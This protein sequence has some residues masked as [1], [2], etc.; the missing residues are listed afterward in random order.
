M[1]RTLRVF[2]TLAAILDGWN[3]QLASG[4]AAPAKETGA[5]ALHSLAPQTEWQIGGVVGGRL[6]VNVDEWLLR[7]PGANPGMIEMFRVR[8]RQPPPQLVPWAGE[9]AGKYLISAVQALMLTNSPALRDHLAHFVPEL[10]A[11]Q[12]DDGYIG[13][14]P[15]AER[16]RGNWDLWGHY[17]VMQGL[18]LWHEF[19]GDEESLRTTRRAADLI[20]NTYLGQTRRVFD[21]GS[22][23]MNMAVLHVLVQLHRLTG[24][25]RYLSM[26]RE[27]EKDWERAGDYLRSGLA[28]TEFF[29]SPRPRWESLPDLQG[30]VELWRVTGDARYR[31]AFLHQWRSIARFD[32]HN[33]GGFSSGEQATGNPWN[34]AAIETCCT[35]AWMALSVDALRLTGDP[36]VADELELSLLN[37]G[38]GAQHP[39]GRWWTYNTPMDG[40][41]EAS[42]HSIVFQARAGT[43][44][45]N[46]CSVNAP[47]VLGL[48]GD[49][50]VMRHAAGLTI[51]WHGP[52]EVATTA[53]NG[54]R[55]R[56][57]STTRF[58]LDGRVVWT[59]APE[60]GAGEFTLRFRVP[61]WSQET[62][63]TL[64]GQPLAVP[65][66]PA[67]LE[68]QRVWQQG[69]KVEMAFDI[70]LR[71]VPGDREALGRV[72]LYCGPLLLAFDP[73]DNAFDENELPALD[74][75]KLVEA[76]V[77]SADALARPISAPA[78][79]LVAEVPALD[80]R[81]LRLCDFASAGATGLRYRSWLPVKSPPPSPPITRAPLD[82]ATM[83][84]GRTML[85]WTT[86]P[87]SL[88]SNYLVVVTRD[89]DGRQTVADFGPVT[90]PRL[91][92]D[93]DSKQRLPVRETLWWK[94]VARGPNGETAS[95]PPLG[96]FVYDPAQPSLSEPE[97]LV[98]G[99]GG[100][101]VQA[102]LRG[103]ARPEYGRIERSPE[104]TAATGRDGTANTA[105]RLNGRNQMM[106]YALPE[107]FGSDYT[108]AVWVRL[109]DL[110]AGR[111]G[112]VLSFWAG[113][114]DDP[115]RLT[116]DDG[117]LFA[118]IE[119]Q[120]VFSTRG[121][122]IAPGAWH[123]V[124]AVKSGSRLT[125]Y[126]DGRAQEA[127]EVPAA[128][129]TT[130]RVCALGGNPNYS[131]N[132]FLAADFAQFKLLARAMSAEEVAAIGRK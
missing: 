16:L 117:K 112:Q 14:F 21:A 77:V 50:A 33:S 115:L 129:N 7:A 107:E 46:C 8:D 99:P 126:L 51:N 88:V 93:H 10:I 124:V 36:R 3:A 91:A 80:G 76:R 18:L 25:P 105:V 20:C 45:L 111:I 66:G 121:V 59:V 122:R 87:D 13:P 81:T 65:R 83:G 75:A 54:T 130:A 92:L 120:R 119:A 15:R 2:V 118:R 86:K 17:H 55:V 116:V 104:F 71:F 5:L 110:P 101:I 108:A 19:A 6:A 90:E 103:D 131:G 47:R 43:P 82:G 98:P 35:V 28:H 23:E 24:E 73:R 100:V 39:S 31:D 85:R 52:G 78:P 106:V 57:K 58:P 26:A 40:V 125:L 74:L 49:W 89:P 84:S 70:R 34:P 44:E 68:V 61:G 94:V 127:I 22:H 132:E 123:H 113:G 63:A 30:L 4:G 62:T 67:F 38:L 114:M 60:A 48:L 53:P 56:L 102:P 96:R 95:Q 29:K 69:D 128:L 27:I 11:C 42:A 64:N 97:E 41:R 12:A 79:W 109:N 1:K 72:S 9:F 32:R 37:G